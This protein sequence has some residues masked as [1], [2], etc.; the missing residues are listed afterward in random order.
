MA[1]ELIQDGETITVQ[2]ADLGAPNADAEVS[3][4]V[5]LISRDV[6]RTAIAKHT[7]TIPNRTTRQ[8]EKVTDWDAVGEDLLDYALVGWAGINLKGQPAPC[9]RAH[10][11]AI[12]LDRA[13]A[14]LDLAGVPQH[15]DPEV[16]R[17]SF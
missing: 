5:K 15:S 12:G 3:Y 16:R 6:Y 7:K 1:L 13:K 14:L 10:K 4:Q 8:L 2:D 11:L 17:A 9:E